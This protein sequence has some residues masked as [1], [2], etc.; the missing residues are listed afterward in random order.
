MS[1]YDDISEGYEELHKEE[2]L[3]KVRLIVS[4]LELKPA[5]TLLDVGCG[6]GM[7][8]Y[9]FKC[10][11]TGVDPAKK[12]IAKYKGKHRI[13]LARAEEL[14]FPNNS[15]DVVTG[16]TVIHN[17]EDIKK[18]MREIKRVGR[19]RFVFSVLKRSSKLEQIERL[20]KKLFGID[21]IIE[22]DKDLIFVC[23]KKI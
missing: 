14:P 16:I 8:L 6:T 4:K 9:L 11:V 5:D 22:E 10:K 1:Y 15:F 12:L 2:Q 17:F 23:H 7:Y 3:K 21:E 20:I 13:M 19:S 18:G